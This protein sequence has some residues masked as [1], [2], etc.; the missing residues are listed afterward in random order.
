MTCID[1]SGVRAWTELDERAREGVRGAAAL[2]LSLEREPRAASLARAAVREFGDVCAIAPADC[3]T[4][5]L[6]VSELVSNAVRHSDAP[7]ASA[8]TVHARELDCGGVRVEVIDRGSGFTV[9]LREPGGISGGYGLCLLDEQATR[10]GVD[11]EDGTRVWFE[12]EVPASA[13]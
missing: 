4:L 13:G 8:I 12:L 2:R 7:S 3:A 1:C 11:R 9:R 10:W 6:L 5:T